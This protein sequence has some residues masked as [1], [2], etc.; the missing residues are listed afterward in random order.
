M[1]FFICIGVGL[2]L[3]G[4]S[5][6]AEESY[7]SVPGA[8]VQVRSVSTVQDHQLVSDEVVLTAR[9]DRSDI[10]PVQR[11]FE[12]IVGFSEVGFRTVSVDSFGRSEVKRV[13]KLPKRLRH[14]VDFYI[15]DVD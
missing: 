15:V 13:V 10:V 12:L 3:A 11:S 9:V 5:L 14:I 8:A 4:C 1:R 6:S 2:V 7:V